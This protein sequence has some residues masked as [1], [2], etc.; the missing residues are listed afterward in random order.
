MKPDYLAD[1]RVVKLP[2]E[3]LREFV[4]TRGGCSEN[5]LSRAT[6]KFALIS[7]AEEKGVD[8]EE[9]LNAV[10]LTILTSGNQRIPKIL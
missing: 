9:V 6:T 3:R 5:E 7:L 10:P 2:I 4:S 1:A 8:L